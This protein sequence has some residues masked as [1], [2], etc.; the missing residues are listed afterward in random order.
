MLRYEKQQIVEKDKE[1]GL[2]RK[3]RHAPEEEKAGAPALLQVR[4]EAEQAEAHECGNE[5][6]AKNEEE[7]AETIPGIVF[8]MH[9]EAFQGE[10]QTCLKQEGLF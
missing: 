5:Q 3:D 1:E 8:K 4:R 10:C 7:T 2:G 9:E 6:A